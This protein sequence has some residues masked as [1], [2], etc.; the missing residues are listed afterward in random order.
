[1]FLLNKSFPGASLVLQ[2]VLLQVMPIVA[3]FSLL[4]PS[5][6]VQILTTLDKL[7]IKHW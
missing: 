6:P 4:F 1:M 2:Q 3:Y 7:L 5:L